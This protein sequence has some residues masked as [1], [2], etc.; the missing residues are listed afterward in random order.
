MQIALRVPTDKFFVAGKCYVA[1]KD[2]CAH[3]RGGFIGFHRVFRELQGGA[4]VAYGEIRLP[5]RP[6]AAPFEPGLEPSRLHV[7][8]EKVRSRSQLN[9]HAFT[10]TAVKAGLARVPVAGLRE[11]RRDHG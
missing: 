1:L 11:R 5:E 2:A 10:S 7:I 4:A 8:D 9:L 6:V 3:A